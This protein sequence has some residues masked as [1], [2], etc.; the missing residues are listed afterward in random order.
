[1]KPGV[2]L[3]G[4]GRTATLI[5][6]T[7]G[8]DTLVL[9]KAGG[10]SHFGLYDLSVSGGGRAI[11]YYSDHT[12]GYCTYV[13]VVR[14]ELSGTAEC[15]YTEGAIEEWYFDDDRLMGGTYGFRHANVDNSGGTNYIDKST[16]KDVLTSGQSE[17]GWD[18]R[19]KT[20]GT[21][22]WI[23]PIINNCVKDGFVMAG[24]WTSTT[25]WNPNTE[26]INYNAQGGARTTGTISAA[27]TS[28]VV[29]SA[30][31]FSVG[32]VITIEGAGDTAFDLETTIT[33]IAGTTF[34]LANAASVSVTSHEV[35]NCI[36]DE[37]R[38]ESGGIS[39]PASVTFVS[40]TLGVEVSGKVRYAINAIGCYDTTIE[41]TSSGRPIYLHPQ[42]QSVGTKT[43]L[44]IP[45]TRN[46]SYPYANLTGFFI[47]PSG[48][49]TPMRSQVPSGPGKPLVLVLRD[50]NDDS[51]GTFGNLSVRRV[52][53]NRTE[54][55][56]LSGSSGQLSL[57][58]TGSSAGLVLGGDVNLYRSAADTAKT[59][60]SLHVGAD[61]RHLGSNLGFYGGTAVAKPSAYTQTYATADK[62][63]SAY[64]SDPESSAYTGIDNTQAGTV[65][66]K[67]ADLNA[68]RTAYDNLRVFTEDA[69]AMLNSVVDDLQSLTLVG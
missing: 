47:A 7:A 13:R 20:G 51:S 2:N 25:I 67:V 26:G 63:L 8:Y 69:V 39:N 55:M 64:T 27:S 11:A 38:F 45:G 62:T 1:L 36:Y 42:C 43:N 57:P 35:T 17:R 15:V 53:S 54:I 16:F 56:S 32:D 60:D 4:A 12:S 3:R 10:N 50:S 31:G 49:A 46:E 29:A 21:N 37:F 44:R 65:Y 19:A 68:L 59:D 9:P 23:N 18:L 48:A 40:G 66:A 5:I 28:L 30:T 52:D 58:L 33:V 14:C 41:G 6:G 34:T 22:T 24:G 61:F